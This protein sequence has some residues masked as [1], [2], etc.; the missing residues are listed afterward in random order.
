MGKDTTAPNLIAALRDQ[1]CRTAVPDLLW[2]DGGPQFTSS[3]LAKF[4]TTW[5]VSHMCSSPHYPQS[6]GKVEATVKSMKKLISGAWMGHNVNWNKLSRSLLQYRNTPCRMDGQHKSCSD[7]LSKTLYLPIVAR[8]HRSYLKMPNGC[9]EKS[10]TSVQ[11]TCSW[12]IQI[13]NR[14]S[15]CNLA[16]KMWDIY[17]VITAIGP[18]RRY[19]VK[20]QSGRVLIRN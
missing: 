15:C 11:P 13:S 20:T 8:S 7:T 19:F 12:S 18:F 2:S 4:L 3:K 17:G 5:G 10:T 1:F 16:S 14:Q 9:R 6:N